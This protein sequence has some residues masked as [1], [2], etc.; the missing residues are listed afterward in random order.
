MTDKREFKAISLKD[1]ISDA[2]EAFKTDETKLKY[3]ILTETT[4]YFGHKDREI[5]IEAW[6]DDGSDVQELETFAKNLIK[7]MELELSFSLTDDKGF[8]RMNFSGADYRLMLYQNANLLNA[9]Q[10]LI[11]RLFSD[12]IG[13]KIFCECENYRKKKEFELS[14]MAHR[15]AKQVR[16]NGRSMELPELNPFERRIIHMTI[17]KYSDLESISNGDDFLKIITI[18]KKSGNAR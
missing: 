1:A 17:N 18:Q 9:I 16:K 15:Y 13:K 12:K 3:R 11:N 2:L 14:S 8:I 4:R 10:Y 5:F 7:D 6:V